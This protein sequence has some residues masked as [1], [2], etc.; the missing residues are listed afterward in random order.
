MI[1]SFNKKIWI[2]TTAQWEGMSS[3][4]TLG[5]ESSLIGLSLDAVRRERRG[6]KDTTPCQVKS[7]M[8]RA[9]LR[10]RDS[11]RPT[12]SQTLVPKTLAH[13]QWYSRACSN[14]TNVAIWSQQTRSN[15]NYLKRK[16]SISVLWVRT[17]Q[18]VKF[19][20]P[21]SQCHTS[22]RY[23][24]DPKRRKTSCHSTACK[25]YPTRITALDP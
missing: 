23:K 2:S 21:S 3:W 20:A 15:P 13:S 4:I 10:P 1:L 5:R 12:F 19:Q 16:K 8:V 18:R 17:A 22:T 25:S 9:K 7:L 24:I 14:R 6:K 11:H